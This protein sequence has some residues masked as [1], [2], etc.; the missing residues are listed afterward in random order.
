M[1]KN[2]RYHTAILP[3]VANICQKDQNYLKNGG[4]VSI[5]ET[6][7]LKFDYLGSFKSPFHINEEVQFSLLFL[8][9]ILILD[10]AD[11]KGPPPHKKKMKGRSWN[12]SK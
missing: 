9:D 5:I 8:E 3:L 12:V 7:S 10:V 4:W 1:T 11:A 2:S 6:R